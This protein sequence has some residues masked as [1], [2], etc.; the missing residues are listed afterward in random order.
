[1]LDETDFDE[2]GF[3]GNRVIFGIQRPEHISYIIQ[4]VRA[5][6]LRMFVMLY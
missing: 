5:A 2:A 6:R 1:M 3:V 4:M